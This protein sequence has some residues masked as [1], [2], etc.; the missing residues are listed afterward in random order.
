MPLAG[1]AEALERLERARRRARSGTGSPVLVAGEARIGKTRL[2]GEL[3]T[4]ARADGFEVL[5]GRCLDL[6]GTGLPYQPFAD[7]LRPL[8][9]GRR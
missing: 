4:R 1:R 9:S 8:A 7:A 3:A 2:A 5:V 6:V